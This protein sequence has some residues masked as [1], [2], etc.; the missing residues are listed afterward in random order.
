ME[1]KDIDIQTEHLVKGLSA[2][3][4]LLQNVSLEIKNATLELTK[5]Q[6]DVRLLAFQVEEHAKIIEAGP[7]IVIRVHD[8][9]NRIVDIDQ[10][11][12]EVKQLLMTYETTRTAV[13]TA[14]LKLEEENTKRRWGFWMAI[15][16]GGLALVSQFLNWWLGSGKV[17]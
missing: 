8:L 1:K 17:P 2:A 6:S 10:D 4:V 16:T 9:E 5:I 11:F 15:A 14:R 7:G 12:Q 13:E 3:T